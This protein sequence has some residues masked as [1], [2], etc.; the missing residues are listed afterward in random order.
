[1]A[2]EIPTERLVLRPWR[3]DDAEDA[4]RV[5][6][7]VDVAR[8][9][10]PA[11]DHVNDVGAMRLVLQGWIAE[12]ER[13]RP[14]NGRWAIE[15]RDDK[16][17]VGGAVLLPLPP[18]GEDLEVGWQVDPE[19]WGKGYASEA[20]HAIAHW[21]FTQEIDEI[22]AVVRPGNTRAAATVQRSGMEWVGETEKYFGLT[23]QVYRLRSAD[24]DGP[25]D[26]VTPPPDE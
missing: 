11:M 16:R 7:S 24:L 21:A 2:P 1:M 3:I 19:E 18:G 6:G 10:S 20:T 15:R 13:M 12:A 25:A 8:W 9:L 14:P 4:L 22:F 26:E 5:Y 17:L 23:L